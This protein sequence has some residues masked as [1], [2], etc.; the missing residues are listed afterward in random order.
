M[1]TTPQLDLFTGRHRV[2]QRGKQSHWTVVKRVCG[3]FEQSESSTLLA[4]T[5]GRQTQRKAILKLGFF[6]F[7][8]TSIRHSLSL[9]RFLFQLALLSLKSFISSSFI[10]KHFFFVLVSRIPFCCS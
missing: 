4:W 6:F 8:S 2:A 9:S 7:F 1:Q 10:P 3:L 5:K